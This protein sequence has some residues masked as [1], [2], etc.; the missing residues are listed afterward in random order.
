MIIMLGFFFTV[1][2]SEGTLIAQVSLILDGVPVK[3]IPPLV[4]QR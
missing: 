2:L 1:I 4:N 3:L